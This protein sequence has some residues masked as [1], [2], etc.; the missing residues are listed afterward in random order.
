MKVTLNNADLTKAVENFIFSLGF[1]PKS[2]E[3]TSV[4]FTAGRGVNGYTA[5]VDIES[6]SAKPTKGCCA[7][8]PEAPVADTEDSSE[9]MEEPPVAEE[10]PSLFEAPE[11]TTDTSLFK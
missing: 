7:K 9:P 1:D 4:D 2:V 6:I 11:S 10:Q 5:E 3:V 8:K